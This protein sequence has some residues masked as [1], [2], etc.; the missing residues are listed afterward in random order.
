MGRKNARPVSPI[1]ATA[2]SRISSLTLSSAL[3]LFLVMS[4][5]DL[6]A[7]R[8]GGSGVRPLFATQEPLILTLE[9]DFDQLKKDR[10]QESE[11]RE[12]SIILTGPGGESVSVPIKVKTRGMF[13]LQKANCSFP[14]LR[15]DLPDEGLEGT[16][17][18]GQDRVKLVVH[19]V[20]NDNYEQ[21]VLEEYLAYRIYNLFTEI[22]FQ[23]R[24][25]RVTYVDSKGK[26]DPYTRV[27][28]LL[29]DEE[30]MATRLDG[31]M[32]TDQVPAADPSEYQQEAVGQM[33]L[34][35][36]LIGNE[37]WSPTHFHNIKLMR[38][39]WEYFPVPY[40]FDFSGL[41]DAPYA[42][43]PPDLAEKID[44][45]RDRLYR[46]CCSEGIDYGAL[47][48]KFN[49]QREAILDLVGS[50]T[51][52]TERNIGSALRY[53]EEFYEIINDARKAQ[54]QIVN[55]CVREYG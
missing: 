34:F 9:A 10:D 11:E 41:V 29:E 12:G 32:L 30:A 42:T 14:P 43:L 38:V 5:A 33:Y 22:S 6:E 18:E 19:C 45:V 36:Y 2:I 50:Q 27:A 47:F 25:A 3:T 49:G 21:N 37:D 55:A 7:V 28:F 46:G 4:P 44:S 51:L 24:L 35:Q 17:L 40:D 54:R 48:A 23:V 52:L 1:R 53:I 31:S 8:Q 20:D 39:G 15:L 13:R 26:D 16:D